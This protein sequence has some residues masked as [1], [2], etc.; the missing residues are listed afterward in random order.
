MILN[1]ADFRGEN[2]LVLD[3]AAFNSTGWILACHVCESI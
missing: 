2:A 1:A 3:V